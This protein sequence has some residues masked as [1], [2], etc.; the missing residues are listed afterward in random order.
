MRSIAITLSLLLIGVCPNAGAQDL[1]DRVQELDSDQKVV[2]EPVERSTDW[3][4]G[5]YLNNTRVS[6]PQM[7]VSTAALLF[8]KH[9]LLRKGKRNYVVVTAR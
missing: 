5:I 9:L 7:K 8:G 2:T 4:G 1:D 3:G 6:D